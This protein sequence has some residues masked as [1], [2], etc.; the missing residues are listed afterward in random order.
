MKQII[1]GLMAVL[2][3]STGFAGTPCTTE[4]QTKLNTLRGTSAVIQ[5]AESTILREINS[6]RM[7][8]DRDVL[9]SSLTQL[10]NQR[11]TLES[12][13]SMIETKYD[14]E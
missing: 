2:Y 13:V 7:D 9:K 3:T 8:L 11:M 1:L 4:I 10:F 12:E 5:S 14:C 6:R